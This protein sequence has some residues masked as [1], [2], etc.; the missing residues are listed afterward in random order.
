MSTDVVWS[1]GIPDAADL[2]LARR[3]TTMMPHWAGVESNRE[4]AVQR[5]VEDWL[6][7]DQDWRNLFGGDDH[8]NLIVEV[9]EPAAIAGRY[10]VG[11][12]RVARA[13]AILE[14]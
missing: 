12:D 5:I 14:R 6:E 3:H 2:T 4:S 10:E 9:H 7:I 1:A 11:V 8:C 13:R